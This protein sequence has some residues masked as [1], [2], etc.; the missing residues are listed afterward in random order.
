MTRVID[1]PRAEE[2]LSDHLEG[3]LDRLLVADLEVHLAECG[4]CRALRAALAEVVDALSSFP[5]LEPAADLAERAAASALRA[6][7]S[8]PSRLRVA[9]AVPPWLQAAA[10]ALALLTTGGVLYA[11]Q[12]PE[13]SRVAA[14]FVDR[15]VNAGAYI[16]ERKDRLVEDVRILRV[17]IGTAFEGRLDRMNDRVDDYR[18]LL[19]KRRA[20]EEEAKKSGGHAAVRHAPLIAARQPF[21]TASEGRS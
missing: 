21:R 13:P 16:L 19:E 10:A 18:R 2:L 15:T 3:T 9:I 17:V 5:S 8:R 11:T 14:R 4:A 7:R 12:S 20:N 6:R 1:C